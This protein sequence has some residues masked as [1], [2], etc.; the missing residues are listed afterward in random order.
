MKTMKLKDYLNSIGVERLYV[1]LIEVIEIFSPSEANRLVRLFEDVTERYKD[2]FEDQ[3]AGKAVDPIQL[4]H[5][6][7]EYKWVTE[8]VEQAVGEDG[9]R[10]VKEAMEWDRRDLERAMQRF[11]DQPGWYQDIDGRLYKYDGVVWGVVPG[12]AL[13]E[14]EYL[15]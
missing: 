11:K 1:E 6:A 8:Q 3:K 13:S 15:G 5:A 7:S 12:C 4:K 14:L 10:N 9:V 2:L